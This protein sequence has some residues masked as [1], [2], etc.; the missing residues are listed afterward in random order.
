MPFPSGLRNQV[1]IMPLYKTIHFSSTTQIFVWEITESFEQLNN[2]VQLNEK[3]CIRLEGMKSE[4][5]QRGFLSVRKLLQTA[6]YT[7]FDLYYDELGKPHLK[8]DKYIS[9]THSHNFSAIIVSDETVGIDIELQRDK[10]IRIADKFVDE[11]FSFLDQ[12]DLESYIKKLT[13]IWGAKEAIFKI[14]NEKGISFKE[15]IK[16]KPFCLDDTKAKAEL[17]FD[18]IVIDFELFY[19]E[20]EGFGLVYAFQKESGE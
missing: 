6:G 9:I 3:N 19:E 4:M 10:I 7:D 11:E 15:H 5:H 2:E 12:N 17:H 1:N 16:V 18:G 20:I 13:V 14:R 8:D